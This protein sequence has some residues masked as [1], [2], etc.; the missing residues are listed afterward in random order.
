VAN[1]VDWLANLVAAGDP[2]DSMGCTGDLENKGVEYE[3]A[4]YFWAQTTRYGYTL[5]Q[6]WDLWNWAAPGT[7]DVDGSTGAIGDDPVVRWLYAE[8]NV[9]LLPDFSTAAEDHG[10]DH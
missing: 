5:P 8:M 4:R 3:W 6:M 9:L 7:W 10:Q 2:P 1:D